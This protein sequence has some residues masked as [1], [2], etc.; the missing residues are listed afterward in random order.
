MDVQGVKLS[1]KEQRDFDYKVQVYELAK[2][3]KDQEAALQN[4]DDY[5]MPDSYDAEG[6]V[7]QDERLK[8]LTARFQ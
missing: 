7:K 1:E 6:S 4:R 5:R 8:L 3:R 2:K